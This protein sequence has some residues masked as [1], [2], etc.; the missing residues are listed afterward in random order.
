MRIADFRRAQVGSRQDVVDECRFAYAAIAA[1][2][3]LLVLQHRQNGVHAQARC[4]RYS[5][6]LIP[7]RL[8]QTHHHLLIMTL[9]V[10]E[11]VGLVEH[12]HRR[13]AVSLSR[14]E[15]AVDEDGAC[16]R[17]VHRN[18]EESLVDV[19]SDDM[20]LL[21]EVLRL[22]YDIVAAVVNG[23]DECRS[24]LIAHYVYDVAHSHRIGAAYAFQAEV[25][26]YLAVYVETFISTYGVPA[27][28]ILYY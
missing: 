27:A 4:S 25:A 20:A 15:E 8:V 14:S 12:Q 5:H 24:F 2:Q 9:L 7:Y 13:H 22:A 11:Y 3:R 23:G 16:L 1:Q 21:A 26:L 18:D 17:I 19:G 6:A 10:G 28:C